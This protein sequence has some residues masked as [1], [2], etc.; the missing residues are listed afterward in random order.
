MQR[1]GTY[2]TVNVSWTSG[3]PGGKVLAGFTEGKILPPSGTIALAHGI[4]E[5]NFTVEVSLR[6]QS[7]EL[8]NNNVP[9]VR[10]YVIN[11]H[12]IYIF[13]GNKNIFYSVSLL[14]DKNDLVLKMFPFDNSH[15][16]ETRGFT[17]IS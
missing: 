12:Q 3:F 1:V 8:L 7:I 16:M 14:F 11:C 15:V 5:R 4:E 10:K 17:A 6:N 2:G 13:V 9:V